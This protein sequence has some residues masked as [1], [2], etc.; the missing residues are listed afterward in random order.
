VIVLMPVYYRDGYVAGQMSRFD[1]GLQGFDVWIFGLP[2]TL[3]SAAAGAIFGSKYN[4]L[5][6]LK[7]P[8]IPR[9]EGDLATAAAVALATVLIGTLVASRVGGMAGR[10]HHRKVDQLGY[11]V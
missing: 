3:L 10:R 8:R 9:K 5:S 1:G 7:L 4:V 11:D 2:I 6:S